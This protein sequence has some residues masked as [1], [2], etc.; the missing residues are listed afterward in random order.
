MIKKIFIIFFIFC[1]S[2]CVFGEDKKDNAGPDILVM[3]I[4]ENNSPAIL[5]ISY[6][7]DVETDKLNM[8]LADLRR[9]F[10]GDFRVIPNDD[11]EARG[12][13]AIITNSPYKV[14]SGAVLEPII[15]T[16]SDEKE[17][18]VLFTGQFEPIKNPLLM[19]E[20]DGFSI[21][22]HI[23]DQAKSIQYEIKMNGKD[24][25]VPKNQGIINVEKV[26]KKIVLWI[27]GIVV[28]LAFILVFRAMLLKSV[29]QE[30][31]RRK[32]SHGKKYEI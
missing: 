29:K 27:V 7:R 22:A 21:I 2:L 28:V 16:F 15:E 11:K 24:M 9:A 23:Q 1:L 20:K 18:A 3:L 13:T 14:G 8:K 4:Y 6:N 10:K 5:N 19:Y 31:K 17:I 26:I 12:I 30:R 25:K 32:N